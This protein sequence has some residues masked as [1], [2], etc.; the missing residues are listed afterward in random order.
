MDIIEIYEITYM[1]IYGL[2][3]ISGRW[4]DKIG[5]CRKPTT[6]KTNGHVAKKDRFVLKHG[7]ASIRVTFRFILALH[8]CS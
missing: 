2:S 6:A 7:G 3:G 1:K 8:Y 4:Y 5:I